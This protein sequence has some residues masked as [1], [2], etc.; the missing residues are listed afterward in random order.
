MMAIL[1]QIFKNFYGSPTDVWSIARCIDE[2][3]RDPTRL[4]DKVKQRVKDYNACKDLFDIILKGCLLAVNSTSRNLNATILPK[5]ENVLP[6]L[7]QTDLEAVA[8]NLATLLADFSTV[9]KLRDAASST[10][11]NRPY[12][13]LLLFIQHGMMLR[14][15]GEAIREGDSGRILMCI[16]YFVVWFQGTSSSNYAKETM[17]LTACI[18]R[19]WSA[20]LVEFWKNNC[21]VRVSG[22]EANKFLALDELNEHLV[23]EVKDMMSNSVNLETDERLRNVLSLLVWDF[24]GIKKTMGIE[25]DTDVFDN[26]SSPPNEWFDVRRVAKVIV[27]GRVLVPS[28]VRNGSMDGVQ[29]DCN[30]DGEDLV[31]W[32]TSYEAVDCFARGIEVL[33]GT[34]A[35]ARLKDEMGRSDIFYSMDEEAVEDLW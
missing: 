31:D 3:G 27:E 21:V 5:L 22:V 1:G 34:M 20:R 17:R 19:L 26:H 7:N 6:H 4:W 10:P 16:S 13:N 29:M 18:R 35:I 14:I 15:L 30:E 33:G 8:Q 12:E 28:A 9:S 23:G 24:K 2:L 25:T 11:R 32:D